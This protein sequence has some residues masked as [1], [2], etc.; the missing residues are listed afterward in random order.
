MATAVIQPAA[1]AAPSAA[2]H[3]APMAPQSMEETGL[4]S[5]FVA[6]LA[7]KVLYE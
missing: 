2:E 1:P 4:T 6:D 3:A 7:L 5:A